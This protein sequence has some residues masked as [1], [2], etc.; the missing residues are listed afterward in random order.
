MKGILQTS[1][2]HNCHPV[3]LNMPVRSL[4]LR[5]PL[6]R[7]L[8]LPSSPS[9]SSSEESTSTSG[10]DSSSSET[11]S[12]SSSQPSSSASSPE[13]T[14]SASSLHSMSPELLRDGALFQHLAHSYQRE[15]RTSS[16]EEPNG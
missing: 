9:G 13:T 11:S 8:C 16:Y 3:T 5:P 2:S 12:E 1:E 15:A 10:T 4:C 14:T 7:L 6:V